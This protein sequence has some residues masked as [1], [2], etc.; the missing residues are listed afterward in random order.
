[1]VMGGMLLDGAGGIKPPPKAGGLAKSKSAGRATQ[2]QV[3]RNAPPA[4]PVAPPVTSPGPIRSVTPPAPKPPSLK[5]FLAGDS[6]YQQAKRGGQ[7]TLQDFLSELER[8]R[9]MGETEYS[10][11][12]SNLERDRELQMERLRNEFAS[13][14]LIH[15]GIYAGEQGEFQEQFL[16]A[17]NQ[18]ER[19]RAN[20][21]ADLEAQRLN[22]QRE[23]EL[24]MEAARQEAIARRAQRYNL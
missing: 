9:T 3:R 5:E 20:F 8:Q 24:A 13:R 22:M 17:R 4:P 14:G 19:Q 18:L 6:I 1:M 12:F 15:S 11:L 10:D 2:Q 21:F 7:R 23:H 16:E